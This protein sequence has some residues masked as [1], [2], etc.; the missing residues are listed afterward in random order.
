MED[1]YSMYTRNY[2]SMHDELVRSVEADILLLFDYDAHSYTTI[3]KSIDVDEAIVAEALENLVGKHLVRG[4]YPYY[5]LPERVQKEVD[6]ITHMA[7]ENSNL[8]R[9]GTR[10]VKHE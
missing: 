1:M 9:D 7:I 3:V 2:G 8:L 6:R 4:N 5:S 10:G